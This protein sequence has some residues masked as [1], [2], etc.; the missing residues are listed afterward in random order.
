MFLLKNY[1]FPGTLINLNILPTNPFKC[2]NIFV[3]VLSTYLLFKYLFISDYF[4][5]A[6]YQLLSPHFGSAV[7]FSFFFIIIIFF[8]FLLFCFV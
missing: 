4:G 2:N 1:I 3:Y 8:F 6:L 7:F 5:I